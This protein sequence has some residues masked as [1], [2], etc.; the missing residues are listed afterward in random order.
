MLYNI[1]SFKRI[2]KRHK[3]SSLRDITIEIYPY[4][5]FSSFTPF[6]LRFVPSFRQPFADMC[7]CVC[8]VVLLK[9]QDE[10]QI[11]LRER[12]A[13]IAVMFRLKI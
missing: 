6:L 8:V 4:E 2:T 12:R 7:V 13:Q 5:F 10:N 3:D 11:Y 1:R 9:Q